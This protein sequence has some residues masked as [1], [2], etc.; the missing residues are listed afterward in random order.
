MKIVKI[1]SLKSANKSAIIQALSSALFCIAYTYIILIFTHGEEFVGKQP[2]QEAV[3]G[4]RHDVVLIVCGI[5]A[6]LVPIMLLKY[7]KAEYLIACL[8]LSVIYYFVI[9]IFCVCFVIDDNFDLITYAIFPIP[10]GSFIGTV[11]SILINNF[12]NRK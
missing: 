11:I 2:T 4:I 12:K 9:M 3:N 10:I 8:P 1:D 5:L 6:G 7:K